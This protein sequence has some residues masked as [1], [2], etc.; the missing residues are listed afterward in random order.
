MAGKQ[1]SLVGSD[2]FNK[3]FPMDAHDILA[4]SFLVILNTLNNTFNSRRSTTAGY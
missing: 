4:G 1:K 2:D 3:F